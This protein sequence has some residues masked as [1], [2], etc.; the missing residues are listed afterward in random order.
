MLHPQYGDVVLVTSSSQLEV[1][2]TSVDRSMA[3]VTGYKRNKL[4]SSC[5]ALFTV[6]FTPDNDAVGTDGM[7]RPHPRLVL[8]AAT[9]A[10]RNDPQALALL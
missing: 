1:I 10:W 5:N 4:R 9:A 3:W 8:I 6:H 7:G 2:I